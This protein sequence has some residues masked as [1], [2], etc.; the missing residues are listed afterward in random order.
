MKEFGWAFDGRPPGW[1][2]AVAEL[3]REGVLLPA[4]VTGQSG[5]WYAHAESIA[6]P[7]RPRTVLL[8]PFDRLVHDRDRVLAL[9]DFFYR[10]E[11]YVPR[12]KRQYGYYVLPI[13]HG[14][15]LIGRVDPLFDRKTGVFTVKGVWAEAEAPA[16]A[17]PA[18]AAQIRDLAGW[19]G[20][21]Q[22]QVTGPTPALWRTA[23]RAL[24]P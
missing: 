18:I 3:V 20:A 7:W 24:G 14:D 8:S 10:L 21:E 11:M 5:E 2:R 12:E 15:R 4:Q 13:L 6:R 1:E 9:F 17:G 22:V 19:V 23:L 16:E